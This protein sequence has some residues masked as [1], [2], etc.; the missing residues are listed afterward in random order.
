M[1]IT[2]LTTASILL[3]T[4]KE[5]L[6]FDPFV[7]LAG[8]LSTVA[9]SHYGTG[10][11]IWITH[12]HIDHLRNTPQLAIE[13][14]G[15]IYCTNTPARYLKSV[16]V[17]PDKI[18]IIHPH[19]RY[20][21]TGVTIKVHPGRHIEF[22]RSLIRNT[23]FNSRMLKYFKNAVLLAKESRKYQEK[24]ETV[25]FEIQ[26]EGKTLILLGSLGLAKQ[27]CYPSEPDILVLPYQGNSNLL[28]LAMEIITLLKPKTIIL[29]HFDDSFPPISKL[30][31]TLPFEMEMEK[32]YPG[33]RVIKPESGKVYFFEIE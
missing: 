11:S 20:Q 30:V 2:W 21:L 22:D 9:L 29:D 16:E 3:E 14:N 8:A 6:L 1:K 7:P 15:P 24:D 23:L 5:T 17:A 19:N 33:T 13:G 26:A 18:R 12:G 10:H 4:E 27:Y 28:P 25:V 31:D 32:Q